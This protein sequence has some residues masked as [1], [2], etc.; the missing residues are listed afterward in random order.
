MNM[1][2][3]FILS[4]FADTLALDEA[5]KFIIGK[6]FLASDIRLF[7]GKV[8]LCQK[9]SFS[10]GRSNEKSLRIICK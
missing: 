5:E 6:T 4:F 9:R 10:V 3:L 8:S 2:D 7:A 1:F